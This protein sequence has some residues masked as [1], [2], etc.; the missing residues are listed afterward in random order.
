MYVTDF[1]IF[2]ASVC[3]NMLK[4]EARTCM[5]GDENSAY[6][7]FLGIHEQLKKSMEIY[8]ATISTPHLCSCGSAQSQC[9]KDGR[10]L[11]P[12]PEIPQSCTSVPGEKQGWEGTCTS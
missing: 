9:F 11:T 10:W 5:R 3:Y 12:F 4:W 6:L 8:S 2:Q 1:T 7:E